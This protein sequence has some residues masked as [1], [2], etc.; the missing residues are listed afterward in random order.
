[1]SGKQPNELGR[2][3]RRACSAK[4]SVRWHILGVL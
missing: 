3:C 2:A 4:L 1:M